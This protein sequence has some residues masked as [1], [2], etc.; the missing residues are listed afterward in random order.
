MMA[1]YPLDSIDKTL[2]KQMNSIAYEDDE[3]DTNEEERDVTRAD[4]SDIGE[5]VANGFTSGTLDN[6]IEWRLE[7]DI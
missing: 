7:F 4:F 2:V 6:G 5:A 1:E 3:D